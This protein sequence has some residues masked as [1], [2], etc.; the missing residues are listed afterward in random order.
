[1]RIQIKLFSI[2]VRKFTFFHADTSSHL[3]DLPATIFVF[4]TP[5]G[6]FRQSLTQ[7]TVSFPIP[8]TGSGSM[9]TWIWQNDVDPEHWLQFY[10]KYV[11]FAVT[12][13]QDFLASF[14]NGSVLYGAQIL[15]LKIISIFFVFAKLFEFSDGSPL[16][17]TVRIK[18]MFGRS[19]KKLCCYSINRTTICSHICTI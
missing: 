11:V 19:F 7:A 12:V 14:F 8:S 10:W 1:M 18:K 3:P 4:L 15:R 13:A 5:L 16:Q 9:W 2:K 6:L 17:A